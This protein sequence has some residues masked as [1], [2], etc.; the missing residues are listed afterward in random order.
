MHAKHIQMVS[1]LNKT[2]Y[3]YVPHRTLRLSH[4]TDRA[5]S[6]RLSYFMWDFFVMVITSILVIIVFAVFGNEGKLCCACLS[7]CLLA[8]G[9]S[10]LFHRVPREPRCRVPA[11]AAVLVVGHSA[12][13]SAFLRLH[14]LVNRIR[15]VCSRSSL[16][17]SAC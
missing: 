3:W 11:A 4:L 2:T 15:S 12:G 8:H 10:F 17:F 7:L 9:S 5:L 13:V 1:G 16:S 14:Q 6:C